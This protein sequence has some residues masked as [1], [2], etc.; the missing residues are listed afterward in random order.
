MLVPRFFNPFIPCKI[1]IYPFA[2][3]WPGK[4]EISLLVISTLISNYRGTIR[5][6]TF[7]PK[8]KN[9]ILEQHKK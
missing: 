1:C 2:F 8:F 6:I 4:V 7:E 9:V 5:T 3:L